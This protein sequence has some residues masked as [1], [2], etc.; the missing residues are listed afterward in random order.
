MVTINLLPVK[1]ELRKKALL[2]HLIILAAALILLA[3]ILAG[4]Q[5]SV[6]NTRN[7]LNE[8]IAITKV[9]IQKLSKEAKEI[10]EFKKRKQ[11]LERKLG[12][13]ANLNTQ[14]TGPVEVLD[15]LSLIIP[16]KAWIRSL[17]N[18]SNALVL[19]GFAV[20]NPTIALL[21]K[22]LQ[23]SQYFTDVELVLS[24]QDGSNHKFTIK[25]K[26]KLPA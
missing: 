26:I 9:E 13:I 3:I 21:M 20:D 6:V 10:E 19:E 12:I 16:E 14:K 25:C 8:E 4:V 1:A 18:S 7:D 15:Q 2:E 22:R 5:T 23:A 17:N 24:Q 11:E